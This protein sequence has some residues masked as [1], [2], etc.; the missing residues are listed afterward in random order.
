VDD[1]LSVDVLERRRESNGDVEEQV[2]FH[3]CGREASRRTTR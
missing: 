2:E 3:G 1:E